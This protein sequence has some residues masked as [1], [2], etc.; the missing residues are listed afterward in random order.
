MTSNSTCSNNH[1]PPNSVLVT[2]HNPDVSIQRHGNWST[3]RC[4]CVCRMSDVWVSCVVCRVA[5]GGWR[6]SYVM[7]HVS[8]VV[9]RMSCGMCRMSCLV[10]RM[11]YDVCRMSYV[12]CDVRCAVLCAGCRVMCAEELCGAAVCM[13][14]HLSCCVVL[15]GVVDPRLV[16][17]LR[18]QESRWL[19][20]ATMLSRFVRDIHNTLC[21]WRRIFVMGH[22]CHVMSS[23][24]AP[25]P[26]PDNF[27]LSQTVVQTLLPQLQL[28][29]YVERSCDADVRTCVLCIM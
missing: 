16:A 10:C 21:A 4:V 7:C 9:C 5:G 8:C 28:L 20:L 13:V 15:C 14:S 6:V 24:V 12:V 3:S 19:L 11:S 22:V 1:G 26:S 2:T 29:W 18:Y 25:P 27:T 23:Y 17:Q